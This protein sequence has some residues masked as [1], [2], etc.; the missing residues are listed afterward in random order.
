MKQPGDISMKPNRLKRTIGFAVLVA[1]VCATCAVQA[2]PLPANGKH[3]TLTIIGVDKGKNPNATGWLK[4]A[5]NTI[6]VPKTGITNITIQQNTSFAVTD[7]YGMDGMASVQ[8]AAGYYDVYARATG[9]PDQWVLITPGASYQGNVTINGTQNF[10]LA[11][12]TLGHTKK[13]VW[14][15]IT[16]FFFP[17]VTLQDNVS[18]ETSTYNGTWVFEIGN[19]SSVSWAYDNHGQSPV[20]IRFYPVAIRPTP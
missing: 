20:E 3:D 2:A 5:R 13:P 9:K 7:A 6:F 1:L 11:N 10:S 16:G 8:L 4:S 18:N 14:E 12:V 15:R 19:L 17:T